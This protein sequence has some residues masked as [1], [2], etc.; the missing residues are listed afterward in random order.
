MKKLIALF[1]CA[2]CAITFTTAVQA[3]TQDAGLDAG[4]PAF[5]NVTA[6]SG[7]LSFTGLDPENGTLSDEMSHTITYET[8]QSG[9]T[10]G[11]QVAEAS[12]GTDDW[13]DLTMTAEVKDN[14]DITLI[15]EAPSGG[16]KGGTDGAKS[17]SADD[18]TGQVLINS[19]SQ[20]R[21]DALVYVK[22]EIDR[23]AL[24]VARNFTATYTFLP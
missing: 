6:V 10:V 1:S 2:L 5:A 20:A 21:A 23:Y 9:R 7:G 17:F 4:V 15:A 3:Q 11:M 22:V 16:A 8:N 18:A 19:I 12:D 13:E 14:A 24:A